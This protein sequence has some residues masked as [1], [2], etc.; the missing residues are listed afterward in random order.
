MGNERGKKMERKDKGNERVK[1]GEREE[2]IKVMRELE[3]GERERE[4]EEKR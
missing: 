2:K 1:K 4:R 3:R